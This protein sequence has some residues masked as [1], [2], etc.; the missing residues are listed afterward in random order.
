MQHEPAILRSP[1]ELAGAAVSAVGRRAL[2]LAW[3]GLLA[4]AAQAQPRDK[5]FRVGYL[6]LATRDEQALLT[7][8]FEEAMRD[9]GY[10]EGRNV[11]YERRFADGRLERLAELAAD[12][13]RLEVD[14]IVTGANPAVLA[15]KQAT[16]TVPVVMA[17][18]RDP[19]AAGF[20]ASLSRPGGNIT[21]MVG[22]P[23]P[24]V[25]A[26]RLQ[27]LRQFAPAATRIA[28]L[29]NPQSPAADTYRAAAEAAAAKLG[30]RLRPFSVRARD[31]FQQAFA[32]MTRDGAQALMV[33][34][35]PVFFTAR[36]Q[37]VALAAQHR[38][39]AT[40]HAREF[41]DVGGL[42]SY[43]ASLAEQ[44]RRAAAYVDRILK[45]ARPG[46]LPVEQATRFEFVVN[47]AAARALGLSFP[48]ALLQ[49][50]DATIEK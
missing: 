21:G 27:L 41:V 29:W 47:P 18:S 32:N 6:Y 49:Q 19:V 10:V 20:V 43:G 8:A 45:G 26:R 23:T 16:S 14:V 1:G 37:V 15:A 17:T 46:D 13:V 50:A 2:L 5:Q 25:Q 9:L 36:S 31:E 7:R 39:P 30:A 3:L 42:M 24:E 28:L 34:P 40:Y 22:D 35:D 4:E 44:F 48:A 12:L 38:L 11:V 33:L